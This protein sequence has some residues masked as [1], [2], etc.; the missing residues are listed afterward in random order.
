MPSGHLVGVTG[1]QSNRRVWTIGPESGNLGVR[2]RLLLNLKAK[3]KGEKRTL[4]HCHLRAIEKIMSRRLEKQ[5]R[6]E[7]WR[8]V[9]RNPSKSN[10][11]LHAEGGSREQSHPGGST[12]SQAHRW[13]CDAACLSTE[14][15]TAKLKTT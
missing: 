7:C 13:S 1:R 5:A 2:F 6:L 15:I 8:L 9:S 12:A 4:G 11:V 10:R 3:G 14:M